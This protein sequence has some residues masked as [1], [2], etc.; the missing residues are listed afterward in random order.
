LTGPQTPPCDELRRRGVHDCLPT[1]SGVAELLKRLEDL[2]PELPPPSPPVKPQPAHL[3]SSIDEILSLLVH[4][5]QAPLAVIEGFAL[6]L[7]VAVERDDDDGIRETSQGIRR[8]GASLRALI[9]SFAEVGA[10]ESGTLSLN[11]REAPIVQLVNLTVEDLATLVRSHTIVI[12]A[13]D[14]FVAEVDSIRIRQVLTNLL[15]NA[16]KFSPRRSEIT[17]GVRRDEETAHISV[18][19]QGPGIPAQSHGELFQKFS[20]LGATGSGTGL[21]LYLSRGIARA[22]AGDLTCDSGAGRGATF[23]LTLPLRKDG[24]AKS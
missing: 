11:L 20:R 13:E 8:A 4:E 16:V 7:Q 15:T 3:R 19:D 21:G 12:D 18:S 9:R 1:E 5:I 2:F 23:T 6:A 24:A 14:D 17:I 10:M 22:H